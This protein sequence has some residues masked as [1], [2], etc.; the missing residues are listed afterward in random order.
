MRPQL[1]KL[2]HVEVVT[3]DL[4]RSLWFFGELLGLQEVERDGERVFLRCFGE[5]DHHSLTLRPGPTGIDHVAFRTMR[6]E[7]VER[8]ADL[9]STGGVP[10]TRLEPGA[11][12]GHGASIRFTAPH[13]DAPIELF[14]DVE[15]PRAP[16]HLRSKLPTNST[17]IT[18][19]SPRRID[20]INFSTALEQL[21]PADAWLS[22]QLGFMRRECVRIDGQLAGT[23]MSVTPQV[24][25]VAVTVD[26]QG[27]TARLNHVAFTMESFADTTRLADILAEHDIHVDV[28]PGRHGVT[29]G[30]FYYVRDP[31]SGHHIELFS[32]G[33][34]IFDPDWEPIE[35]EEPSFSSYG[36]K[37]F[38]P[39]W[40]R[41]DNPNAE[42]TACSAADAT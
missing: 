3:P 16:E 35:W 7:D 10:V 27:R 5:L 18:A 28:A 25:D 31:G 20:H 36:L 37:F 17:R 15:R 40:T 23:W 9:L 41:A 26:R 38:G 19:C 33:Y 6:R 24:H 11:E 22:A 8:F 30:H 32:G 34:L 12:R 39:R 14:Y 4:D 2:A 13:I 42:N 29:Q 21:G 1:C